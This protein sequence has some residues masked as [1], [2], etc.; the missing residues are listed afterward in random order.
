MNNLHN[1]LNSFQYTSRPLK[2]VS[3]ISSLPGIDNV[4]IAALH[5]DKLKTE[6]TGK[7]AE[8]Q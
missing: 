7:T 1:T 8:V 6:E 2:Q 3:T 4:Y 5:E